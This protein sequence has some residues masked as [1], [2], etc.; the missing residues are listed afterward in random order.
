VDGINLDYIRSMGICTSSAC[1]DD[2][3]AKTGVYYQIDYNLKDKLGAARRRIQKWQ[4]D[5]VGDV[6]STFS[7]Q[8]REMKPK[9]VISVDSHLEVD[10][11]AR[12]LQGR[13]E[14]EW[15]NRGWIDIIFNMDYQARVDF[16]KATLAMGKLPDKRMMIELFGNYEHEDD[17]IAPRPGEIVAKYMGF[18]QRTWPGH[19][20]ALYLYSMLSDK[21]INALKAGP[22]CENAIPNWPRSKSG[23]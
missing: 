22:F 6:V 20:M 8:A 18:A 19:G 11:S 14:L 17:R 15:A 4:D 23:K 21:Q 3:L 13:N 7:N 16:E 10:E 12:Q 9:L 5:A 2:Y 1:K